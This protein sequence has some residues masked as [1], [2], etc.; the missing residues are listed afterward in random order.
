[1]NK[2]LEEM[3]PTCKVGFGGSN[4]GVEALWHYVFLL[5]EEIKKIEKQNIIRVDNGA[6]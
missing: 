3:N 4:A 1:M 6:L 2:K 5:K